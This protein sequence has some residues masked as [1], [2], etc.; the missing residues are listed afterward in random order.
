MNSPYTG[1][2]IAPGFWRIEEGGVRMFLLEGDGEALLVD[3]GF[4]S[5]DLSAF[6]STLT[7][8]P[9]TRVVVTH[10]DGDHTGALHQFDNVLMH[11][12]EFSRYGEKGGD[13]SR[14][15]PLWEGETLT[16]GPW[17]FEVVL[18]CAHTPGSI[19]LLDR[20]RRVLI[21][22]DL[23]QD[24]P[25]YMFGD[26]RCLPAFPH[27]MDRLMALSADFAVI[28]SSHHTPVLTP[29]IL[30]VLKEG[31]LQVL[32]GKVTDEPPTR[33]GL[34]CRLYRWKNTAF[35]YQP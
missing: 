33:E 22:G 1:H 26:G 25:I 2:L 9:V 23:V 34:P 19:A 24:G 28:Y 5:G 16:V 29:D 31:A 3:A 14:L 12:A 10:S 35:L 7:S 15:T 18:L 11:P 27:A 13:V 8:A 32:A 21:G 20:N 17:S 30:P 4:G 6:L